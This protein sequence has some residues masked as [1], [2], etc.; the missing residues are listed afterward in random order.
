[1]TIISLMVSEIR[2]K[3]D[4]TVYFFMPIE[5]FTLRLKKPHDLFPWDP[6]DA[7]S[8]FFNP[9][10]FAMAILMIKNCIFAWL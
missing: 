3:Y 7:G 9:T 5:D 2:Q 8:Y 6:T 1:M 4:K 10:F